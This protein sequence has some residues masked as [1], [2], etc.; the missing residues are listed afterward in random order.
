MLVTRTPS[1]IIGGKEYPCVIGKNG[2]AEA[3]EKREGDNKTPVGTFPLR[4]V[5]YRAD[6]I[7]KPNCALPVREITKDLGWCDDP[8]HPEYNKPVTLPFSASHEEMWRDD[9]CYDLVVIIGYNDAP[10][11]PGN[12]SAIFIHCEHDDGRPT[13]GCVALSQ[14]QLVKILPL[15]SAQTMLT[16]GEN[17]I[18]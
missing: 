11:I 2:F 17:P 6:R 15:L 7:P 12:G 10:A 8:A 1:L 4:E 18:F 9:H 3:G 14:K 16:L 13:A 5:Y